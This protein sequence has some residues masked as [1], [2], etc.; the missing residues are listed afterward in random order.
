[1]KV[2]VKNFVE[3]L[4]FVT[5]DGEITDALLD[6]GPD[7]LRVVGVST[8]RIGAA[9]GLL[10]KEANFQ[11]YT[12]MQ[13]AI[14]DTKR[15]LSQLKIIG[16]GTAELSVTNNAFNVIGDEFDCIF[17]MAA[18]DVLK[19]KMDWPNLGYKSSFCISSSIFD[20][21]RKAATNLKPKD[22]VARV[23][24][25]VFYLQVGEGISDKG[26]AKADAA[27]FQDAT[28]VY[29]SDV[30]L[31][32]TKVVKGDVEIAFYNNY[33]L[34]MRIVNDFCR[35]EWMVSPVIEEE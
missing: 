13:V 14:P 11:D 7:G 9:N 3:F 27:G 35:V 5:V 33:P 18:R 6:F 8:S 16:S 21:A 25:G 15:L 2:L 28:S 23:T 24:D 10:F 31:D 19:C 4:K 17:I 34:V 32:F 1:M 29:N 22:I 30:L 20:N 12:E 26:I